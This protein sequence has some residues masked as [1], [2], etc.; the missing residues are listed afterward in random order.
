MSVCR[1]NH[2]DSIDE[3]FDRVYS[4]LCAIFAQNTLILAGI[5]PKIRLR[6]SKGKKILELPLPWP[7]IV[8]GV[9]DCFSGDSHLEIRS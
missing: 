5:W 6:F 2:S 4:H 7:Y 3:W 9:L 1:T 8:D